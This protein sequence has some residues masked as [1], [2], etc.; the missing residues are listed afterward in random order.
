MITAQTEEIEAQAE[1]LLKETFGSANP[2]LP[3]DVNRLASRLG[4]TIKQ[5]SFDD[6][7]IA[8]YFN[9]AQ[10]TIY[11]AKD[12]PPG[13]QAFSVAHEL[14]HFV[15]HAATD[16]DSYY[17]HAELN[18]GS[19]TSDEQEANRFAASLLMPRKLVE[20]YW[21]AVRNVSLLASAF[22][23]SASAMLYRLRSL[24]LVRG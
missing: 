18:L 10:R 4:I 24:H 2:D 12:E 6:G 19:A 22:G 1:D 13:R 20:L 15:R 7:N 17:R 8:G 21:P 3:I 11:L 5:G 23:V 14:G 9:R 16:T